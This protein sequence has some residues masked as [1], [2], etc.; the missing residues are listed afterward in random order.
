M[1]GK[2]KSMHSSITWLSLITIPERLSHQLNQWSQNSVTFG[3]LIKNEFTNMI[4]VF[5][6]R[7]CTS[8]E[9]N[10]GGV[11]STYAVKQE[12]DLQQHQQQ[13]QKQQQQLDSC[14]ENSIYVK[15]ESEENDNIP[16]NNGCVCN[17]ADV[18]INSSSQEQWELKNDSEIVTTGAMVVD[19][20]TETAD[21]LV[22]DEEM[23]TAGP[24]VDAVDTE[25]EAKDEYIE[26]ISRS[27][28]KRKIKNFAVIFRD[29]D[30]LEGESDHGKVQKD[31]ARQDPDFKMDDF[32]DEDE[33]LENDDDDDVEIEQQ[34]ND[35]SFHI[36]CVL[37][38]VICNDNDNYKQHMKVFHA[39]E[40]REAIYCCGECAVETTNKVQIES[41][42][43][44]YHG[45]TNWKNI[46]TNLMY[47]KIRCG[48]CKLLFKGEKVYKE[49]ISAC[50]GN[51]EIEPIFCCV[52]C[53][54]ETDCKNKMY[55]HVCNK[56]GTFIQNDDKRILLHRYT[57]M[58]C[59]ACQVIYNGQRDY[60]NHVKEFHNG[61][62]V[63]AV[64]CCLKCDTE[65]DTKTRLMNHYHLHHDHVQ[66]EICGQSF[67]LADYHR[68]HKHIHK[69]QI[70]SC[71]HCD[72]TF[73]APYGLKRHIHIVHNSRHFI[74][75]WQECHKSFKSA[76]HLK[77]HMR[78]HTGEKP[79]MCAF[80]GFI[81]AQKN[82]Y[83]W[84][85]KSKHKDKT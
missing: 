18:E 58:K 70:Y 30:D 60:R 37:C 68:Y 39:D 78:L 35:I 5:C 43:A 45:I 61:T 36:K 26:I 85:I 11:L 81:C 14:T 6:F 76:W 27:G 55:S 54:H 73:K 50:H 1:D 15:N 3:H 24:M 29:D 38:D 7:P 71:Q 59:N 4:H 67:L 16:I 63:K 8:V 69:D 79:Y 83:D 57:Q 23:E 84:H 25:E 72:K 12:P 51:S 52:R 13:Q 10:N 19:E 33:H 66:C 80:C 2:P 9:V 17:K 74:C 34:E 32:S 22:D 62:D 46:P 20:E 64:F 40:D 56:H 31:E 42:L 75:E 47:S 49:H 28:R 82:S 65:T 41:H 21:S 48:E 77:M 53:D 44:S